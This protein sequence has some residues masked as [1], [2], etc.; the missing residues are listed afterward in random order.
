MV[1][2]RVRVR[3]RM[4]ANH[5]LRRRSVDA[6]PALRRLASFLR[7]LVPPFP[8]PLADGLCAPGI[9]PLPFRLPLPLGSRRRETGM[10][11]RCLVRVGVRVRVRVR[12]RVRVRGS[13]RTLRR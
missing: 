5:I 1:R 3:V 9:L 2:V 13:N 6:P 12:D 11:R 7:P 4:R 10:G 8:P